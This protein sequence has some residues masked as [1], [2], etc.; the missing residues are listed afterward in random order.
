[1][2]R[3]PRFV[4]SLYHSFLCFAERKKSL[5]FRALLVAPGVLE[6]SVIFSNFV[7]RLTD[8][9]FLFIYSIYLQWV[10][11]QVL[12]WKLR[13]SVYCWLELDCH[14]RIQIW[15]VW[16]FGFLEFSFEYFDGLVIKVPFFYCFCEILN[17][18]VSWPAK[19]DSRTRSASSIQ[20]STLCSQ[21]FVFPIP[22]IIPF[23]LICWSFCL[24]MLRMWLRNEINPLG[25]DPNVILFFSSHFL[26]KI[27][28]R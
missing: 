17:L 20:G 8:S 22:I 25:S 23:E 7:S 27:F 12:F 10:C 26:K 1:M 9:I 4:S 14:L 15:E 2:I 18:T 16:E 28:L 6:I 5:F 24:W 3:S 21:G 13:F 19:L 11:F